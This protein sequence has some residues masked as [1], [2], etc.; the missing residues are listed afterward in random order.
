MFA[1]SIMI[2]F[3]SE[4]R[5]AM[6]FAGY[7]WSFT[8]RKWGG[9]SLD[10]TFESSCISSSIYFRGSLLQHVYG[11][12][13][14]NRVLLTL[15]TEYAPD[16]GG[17]LVIYNPR[18]HALSYRRGTSRWSMRRQALRG[19]CWHWC[20]CSVL[21]QYQG[22]HPKAKLLSCVPLPDRVSVAIF[23][24]SEISPKNSYPGF[25]VSKRDHVV[26]LYLLWSSIISSSTR[27]H[28]SLM[29]YGSLNVSFWILSG[30]SNLDEYWLP[31]IVFLPLTR[32]MAAPSSTLLLLYGRPI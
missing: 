31:S 16:K 18:V 2:V 13:I 26:K 21:D 28:L 27:R 25:S 6:F 20:T 24:L 7:K 15:E 22:H 30:W 17:S 32:K 5:T 19:R 29:L 3:C 14:K 1:N 10:L 9:M 12:N 23:E 11:T 4:I 8:E